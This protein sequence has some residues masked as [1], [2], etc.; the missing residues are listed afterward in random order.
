MSETHTAP[1]LVSDRI[2]RFEN[3]QSIDQHDRKGF[4]T[5]FTSKQVISSIDSD[6]SGP[7]QPIYQS[8]TKIIETKTE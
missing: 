3:T 1:S 8:T 5:T 4:G 7:T 6:L 2:S